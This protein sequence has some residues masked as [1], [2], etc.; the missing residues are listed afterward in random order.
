MSPSFPALLQATISQF[1]CQLAACNSFERVQLSYLIVTCMTYSALQNFYQRDVPQL[2]SCIR[3]IDFPAYSDTV[4]SDTPLTVTVLTVPNWPSI[5]K[6]RCGYS[7]TPLTV[8][9][10]SSPEGVTVSGEVCTCACEH[11]RISCVLSM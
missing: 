7:D 9:L 6:K 5:Y 10:F 1:S 2:L 11:V 3:S 4:Y 8:T